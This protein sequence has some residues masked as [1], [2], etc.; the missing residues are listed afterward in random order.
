MNELFYRLGTSPLYLVLISFICGAAAN[1]LPDSF[2]LDGIFILIIMGWVGW[3]S[4]NFT[5][6]DE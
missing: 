6:I 5:R 2:D 1:R 3:T 4:G